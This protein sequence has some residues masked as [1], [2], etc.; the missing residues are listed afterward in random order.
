[1]LHCVC[2]NIH[3]ADAR[4]AISARRCCCTSADLLCCMFCTYASTS[5]HILQVQTLVVSVIVNL[6]KK[7]DSALFKNNSISKYNL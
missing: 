5:N 3:N 4:L 6:V 1:M 7:F 2:V